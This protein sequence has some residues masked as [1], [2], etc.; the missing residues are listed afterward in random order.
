MDV[1]F[2]LQVLHCEN[3]KR[4][5][6]KECDTNAVGVYVTHERPVA[7]NTLAGLVLRSFF[8]QANADNLATA[9]V[10]GKRKREVGLSHRRSLRPSRK[11]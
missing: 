10:T 1:Q 6:A 7:E 4:A 9:T 3:D 2:N 5:E 11:S 8:L